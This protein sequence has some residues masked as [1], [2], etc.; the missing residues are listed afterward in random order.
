MPKYFFDTDD[1]TNTIHDDIGTECADDQAARD[2]GSRALGE[3][4]KDFI[5]GGPP[6]KNLAMWVRNEQG[7]AVMQLTM[8]FSVKPLVKADAS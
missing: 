6:Q 2:E 4:A 8:S 5:P 7:Q 3:M 1:G